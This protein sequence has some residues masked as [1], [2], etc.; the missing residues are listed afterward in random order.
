M[1]KYRFIPQAIFP[2]LRQAVALVEAKMQDKVD[3][4]FQKGHSYQ[5]RSRLSEL[6]AR[7]ASLVPVIRPAIEEE[8]KV[9]GY[10]LEDSLWIEVFVRVDRTMFSPLVVRLRVREDFCT[11]L[12][13]RST[14]K[15]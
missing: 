3:E 2:S 11:W 13:T 4:L 15:M 10:A 9:Y 1:T 14:L 5:S 7:P 6:I 12:S 8:L